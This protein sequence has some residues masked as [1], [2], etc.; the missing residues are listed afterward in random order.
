LKGNPAKSNEYAQKITKADPN[1]M[2][3]QQ[4]LEEQ[5]QKQIQQIQ[6]SK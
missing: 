3:K 4:V 1:F 5:R 6:Q 2:Q